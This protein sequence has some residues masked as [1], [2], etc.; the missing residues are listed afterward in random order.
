MDITE[1]PFGVP[2]ILHSVHAGKNLENPFGAMKARCLRDNRDA[3]EEEILCHLPK[4]R[5][6][7]KSEHNDRFLRAQVGGSCVF[8]S[9]EV[10]LWESFTMETDASCRLNFVSVH[11][12]KTLQS[13]QNEHRD[14]GA[15]WRTFASGAGARAP[16]PPPEL[17]QLHPSQLSGDQHFLFA[18]ELAKCGRTADEIETLA[19]CLFKLPLD[20]FPPTLEID[21]VHPVPLE[22]Q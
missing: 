18:L 1:L 11:L 2:I 15:A 4:D 8:D 10:G 22:K 6:A 3:Y 19:S 17:K 9:K 21:S 7:I 16:L 20:G 12:G 13:C 14:L 5:V